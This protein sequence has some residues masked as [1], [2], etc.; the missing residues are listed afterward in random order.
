MKWIN[1]KKRIFRRIGKSLGKIGIF[2][3]VIYFA[4]CGMSILGGTSS[5]FNDTATVSDSA[6]Q[7]GIFDLTARSG[8]SNFVSGADSMIPGKQVARDIYVGKTSLSLPLKH[9]VDF[10]FV[11][12]DADLCDQLD[13]KI[14][15]D[16]Y[17]EP[18]NR[19]MRLTYNGKL[20]ALLDYGNVDFEIPHT[21]DQF[22]TNSSNGTEQWFY[23]SITLPNDTSDDF[24]GKVCNFKFV[25]NAWQNNL[26]YL[27]GGFTDKEE[28]GST[29]KTKYWNSPVVLNE[30]LPNAGEYP[31]F[32]EIYNQTGED[33]DLSG[34]YIMANNNEIPINSTTTADYSGGSTV[35]LANGWLVVTTGGDLMDNNSG[36]ITLY[37]S[38]DVIVDTY[39]YGA[40][41]N[42]VNNTPGWTNN[43]IAYLPFDIDYLDKSGNGNDGINYGTTL[44]TGK[45]NQGTSFDGVNDYVEISHSPSIN[46]NSDKITLEAWVKLNLLP[47]IGN[48]WVVLNKN[49]AYALQVADEGKVRAWIGP[50]TT[51][52]QTDFAELTVD[53]WNHLVATYDGSSIKIYVNGLLKKQVAKIGNQSTSVNN[54][55]IGAKSPDGYFNGSID[56]VKIYNR[57]LDAAEILNHY[58][59]TDI[60][61]SVPVDKSYARIPDGSSNWIDPVP[62]PGQPNVL[63]E[64]VETINQENIEEF[65]NINSISSDEF[66]AETVEETV[67]QPTQEEQPTEEPIIEET[68]EEILED[69][70]L[71]TEPIVEAVV[72][73]TE[74]ILAT[75]EQIIT[76][77]PEIEQTP[78][79]EEVLT[80]EEIPTIEE[81]PI[82][83]TEEVLVQ[84]PIIEE[85]PIVEEPIL[86]E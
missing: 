50:L 12:G 81:T 3:G 41:E 85:V 57:A 70:E 44:A 49:D 59:A 16:H 17:K 84:E 43:L 22:D 86:S 29:I 4:F 67:N 8:Q 78:T 31:E 73:K 38:N 18:G 48:R 1:Y 80:T 76:E 54:L 30:F 74:E 28:L 45:I 62:T 79:I 82:V 53:S 77:E 32:I 25:F 60:S 52:I 83:E 21:D 71:P 56:E 69:A 11:S 35:I 40:S 39:N 58:S 10:E 6:L 34:F 5:Y 65:E 7:A 14:W 42:N 72:E 68:T 15:Y 75:E 36:I 9:N 20:S 13:L 24:Q 47:T 61:G 19:D 33:I 66:I 26:D 64:Q 51:Y 23:Y 37:N 55:I 46:I 63:G 2:A 27:S